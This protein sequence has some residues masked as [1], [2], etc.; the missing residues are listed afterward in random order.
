MVEENVN[1]NSDLAAVRITLENLRKDIDAV[2]ESKMDDTASENRMVKGEDE[3]L[4]EL[5]KD[6]KNAIKRLISQETE[7][8][9]NEV[10]RT[11]EDN[12]K[13]NLREN[14]KVLFEN[15]K[16]THLDYDEVMADSSKYVDQEDFDSISNTP[17]R[18]EILFSLI[19]SRREAA[20]SR[21]KTKE[22]EAG[23]AAKEIVNKGAITSI[24]SNV[25]QVPNNM[26]QN[27]DEISDFAKDSREKIK[28]DRENFNSKDIADVLTNDIW[29]EVFEKRN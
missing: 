2:K 22:K 1:T 5:Y 8:L 4:T 10:K 21:A 9:K 16:H 25:N 3:F 29:H 11:T 17:K 6:P 20:L 19:K 13:I 12:L 27:N 24:P 7:P 18:A 23:Q 14:D 15:L 28:K 26:A